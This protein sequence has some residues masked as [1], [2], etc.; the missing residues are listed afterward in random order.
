MLL[1]KVP[2]HLISRRLIRKLLANGEDTGETCVLSAENNWTDTFTGL[3]KYKDG[4]EIVY[5]LEEVS[6]N[7]Y[8]G[9]ITGDASAGFVITN[10]H[11]PGTPETP[12]TPDT[13]ED[14]TPQTGDTTNLAL[15]VAFLAISGTDLTA[16][17]IL[18]KRKRYCRK[19][20][21]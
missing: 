13:P 6:V 3:D 7:G 12:G 8:H 1:W 10:S 2:S 20:M 18:G 11:T 14:D 21:R 9:L 16:T 17:L 4:K 19:H 5:T 15:W